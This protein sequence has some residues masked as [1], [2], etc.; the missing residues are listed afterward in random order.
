MFEGQD[1][2]TMDDDKLR[3]IRGNDV[4][5][6]FQDPLSAMH[7]FYQ[8][9]AQLVEAMQA[10]R[11]ISKLGGPGTRG[12][13]AGAR[14]HPGPQAPRRPVPARV[15]R[16]HAPAGDDR[17]GAGQRAQAADRRRADDGAGCDCPGSD[18][19]AAGGSPGAAGHG[20]HH[21][22][23][24]PGRR[25]RDRRR[26]RRHVRRADRRARQRP[27]RS[28]TS[29]QHPYTWG[30]LSSIPRLD[31]PRDEE[32][33]P[34]SGR[35]PSLINRPSGCHF[36]PRCP[37]VRDAHKRVDPQLAAVNGRPAIWPRACS[38]RPVRAQD[39]GRH[40]RPAVTVIR[41]CGSPP[42]RL[43]PRRR[44]RSPAS[45]R[46]Q[47]GDRARRLRANP[48][49]AASRAPE[50]EQRPPGPQVVRTGSRYDEMT[51]LIEVR[52]LVKH[53]PIKRGLIFQRQIG[54]VKA[55]DGVS[56]DVEQGETLGIVGETGCGKS[57]TAR[58]L[59]R[60]MD[61]TSRIDHRSTAGT[62]AR[63]RATTSRRC[64]AT[65]RWSSRTRTRR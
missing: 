36:H 8:V 40:P 19:G 50:F 34:I 10:H 7:P 62:S 63:R 52:D 46:D 27:R 38:S 4:A 32:L 25:R 47:R 21:H 49:P 41:W 55:V 31:N 33:V 37:Y 29:P 30:L 17:D 11:R 24:R 35:P 43:R 51:T 65:C 45:R 42:R 58:L 59:C 28:S 61:P 2:V 6:I 13:A 56:F 54:A 3:Q 12:R 18:P 1:I 48:S 44:Q 14:R 16:R 22:H 64:T 57:T 23:P 9:G 53:F 26:D 15:L 39:L 60:L 20:D 5:M